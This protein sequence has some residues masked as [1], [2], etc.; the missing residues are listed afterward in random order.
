M[1]HMTCDKWHGTPD[2][3]K[4]TCDMWW[5][6]SKNV[7]SLALMVWEWRRFEDSEE[8]ADSVNQSMNDKGVCRTAPAT[9]GLLNIPTSTVAPILPQTHSSACLWK[10]VFPSYSSQPNLTTLRFQWASDNHQWLLIRH[11][12]LISDQGS[13]KL[14]ISQSYL[15]CRDWAAALSIT[16]L[17][18]NTND[19]LY[20]VWWSYLN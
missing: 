20:L 11:W 18:Q 6:F 12:A 1:W 15:D 14:I 3:W 16:A 5:T 17:H 8:K 10:R 2:M 9:P 7:S 4:V 13:L 19:W